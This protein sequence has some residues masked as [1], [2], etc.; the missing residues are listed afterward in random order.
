MHQALHAATQDVAIYCLKL[1]L[2]VVNMIELIN[3]HA[4]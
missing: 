4:S 2:S 1:K 3:L